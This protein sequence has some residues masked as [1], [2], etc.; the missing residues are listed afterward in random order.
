[1]GIEIAETVF[2]LLHMIGLAGLVAAGILELAGK[3]GAKAAAFHSG[4]LQLITGIVLVGLMYAEDE[5]PNNTKISVKLLVLLAIIGLAVVNR[6]K[7]ELNKTA[8][9]VI[10]LLAVVNAV[11]AWA[12]V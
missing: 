10:A 2:V 4:L 11:I 9:V 7:P 5:A 1:M 12:W 6:R 3:M 8:Y